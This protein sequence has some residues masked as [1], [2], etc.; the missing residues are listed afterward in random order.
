[1]LLT[2]SLISSAPGRPAGNRTNDSR[3]SQL[4]A[5]R[6]A[7]A[8][9]FHEGDGTARAGSRSAPTLARGSRSPRPIELDAET[10]RTDEG[11]CP[12]APAFPK[13]ATGDNTGSPSGEMRRPGTTAAGGLWASGCGA[14]D[15]TERPG[16]NRAVGAGR[17]RFCCG[18]PASL[19][20]GRCRR[21][22]SPPTPSHR[23]AGTERSRRRG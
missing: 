21:R 8:G 11:F 7:P 6:V 19:R 4:P 3:S 5:V 18:R 23:A 13:K 14:A 17:A 20:T 1:M 2:C 12:G 9:A 16:V 22:R 10:V 15:M